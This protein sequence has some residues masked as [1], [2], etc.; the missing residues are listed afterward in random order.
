MKWFFPAIGMWLIRKSG[1]EDQA[2][3]Q[4][5]LHKI[6]E[7]LMEFSH[8]RS[9]R[10]RDE[11]SIDILHGTETLVRRVQ[12]FRRNSDFLKF[13]CFSYAICID[14]KNI[15]KQIVKKLTA[16][17]KESSVSDQ[18]VVHLYFLISIFVQLHFVGREDDLLAVIKMV[19][20]K[21]RRRGYY[22]QSRKV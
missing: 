10:H 12:F 6:Q 4:K 13:A 22:R 15:K 20:A 9:R 1:L 21:N 16:M 2:L 17:Q 7:E 5:Q 19:T 8:A 18:D 14:S 11:E 3:A